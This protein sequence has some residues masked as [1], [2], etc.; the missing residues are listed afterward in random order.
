MP[1]ESTLI[2]KSKPRGEVKFCPFEKLDDLSLQKIREFRIKPFGRIQENCAH[3][4]YNS[5]K[6]DFFD[7]T[8]RESFEGTGYVN[9]PI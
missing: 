5:G 3:I 4:P 9:L 8:G 2:A 1:K 7:K 6:K